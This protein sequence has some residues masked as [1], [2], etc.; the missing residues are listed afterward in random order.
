MIKLH[1]PNRIKEYD[2]FIYSFKTKCQRWLSVGKVGNQKDKSKWEDISSN[3]ELL[4]LLCTIVKMSNEQFLELAYTPADRLYELHLRCVN[5][6]PS[7]FGTEVPNI[8]KTMFVECGYKDDEVKWKMALVKDL[9]IKACPYC[10]REFISYVSLKEEKEIR[11][12]LDHFYPKHKYPELALCLYNLIPSCSV[13]NGV[14]GK[15]VIDPYEKNMLNPFLLKNNDDLTFRVKIINGL[16]CSM[17]DCERAFEVNISSQNEQL[18]NNG[19]VFHVEEFYNTHTDYAA[20]L[21]M[22]R[23]LRLHK[24]YLRY[25]QQ[26][27]SSGLSSEDGERLFLGVYTNPDDFGKRPMSKFVTDIA[28]QMKLI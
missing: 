20:E 9:N 18:K 11:P 2:D 27:T 26:W 5:S 24:H 15:H 10:N 22:K 7:L 6:W 16:I 14:H 8:V 1:H 4:N 21:Y 25:I 28:K 3:G 23:K 13:C 12:D 19:R 17:K